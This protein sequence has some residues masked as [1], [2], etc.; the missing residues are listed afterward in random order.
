MEPG[1]YGPTYRFP[2]GSPPRRPQCWRRWLW[3]V[4]VVAVAVV[5]P[6]SCPTVSQGRRRPWSG[7]RHKHL[8]EAET[9]HVTASTV[10][11]FGGRL[12]AWSTDD[13]LVI[14]ADRYAASYSRAAGQLQWQANPP[15]DMIFCGSGTTI[16]DNQVA[17]AFGKAGDPD[18]LSTQS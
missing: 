3:L 6:S 2:D 8:P 7:R 13:A 9:W 4:P 10:P 17:L 18:R 15:A 12:A 11:P 5:R 16:V 14:V 1:V